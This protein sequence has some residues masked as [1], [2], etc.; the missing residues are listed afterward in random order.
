MVEDTIGSPTSITLT[1]QDQYYPWISVSSS[2]ADTPYVSFVADSTNGDYLLVGSEGA[3]HYKAEFHVSFSG[4]A[5]QTY[6]ATLFLDAGATHASIARGIGT[7][8]DVGAASG[9]ALIEVADGQKLRLKFKCSTAG[10][11]AV[12]IHV[13]HVM[14]RRVGR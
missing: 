3:G 10:S 13:C 6:V 9:S 2:H 12:G 5:S 4:S 8:G 7:A 14:M 11:K 1:T